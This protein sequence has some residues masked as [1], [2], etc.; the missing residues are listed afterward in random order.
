MK[1]PAINGPTDSM[2][3]NEAITTIHISSGRRMMLIPRAR[4]TNGV[5]IKLIPPINT[6]VNSRANPIT[7][8]LI[9]QFTPIMSE[10]TLRG[11][12]PVQPPANGPP[13]TKNEAMITTLEMKK[14]Q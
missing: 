1:A 9:P 4:R 6:A 14:V 11:A 3:S 5:T 12:Y 10:L 8:R 13:G 2:N 7:Q